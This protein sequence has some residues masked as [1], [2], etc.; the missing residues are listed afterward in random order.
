M[1]ILVTGGAGFI[2]S[3]L[4]ERLLSSGHD[5]VVI[6]NFNNFYDPSQKRRNIEQVA[7]AACTSGRD[8]ILCDGDIRDD[9]FIA[10]VFAQEKPDLVIH[11]AAAAGVR[12]SIENPFLY[13]A[14]NVR[15]T[16]N[17]LE[18]ARN[19][20]VRPFIFASSSS[21]YG[22][23]PKVPFAESD[24]V[25]NPISP[26]AA[27][28]KAGEL[29]CHTYHHLHRMNIACLRFFT[30]YGPRQR[31]DL[32]I[33]KFT[34][35]TE[36]GAPI[37]FYGD[38]TTSRDYTY[39]GDIIDGVE[40]AVA[41]VCAD[42]WRYD[43][44]NLGESRPVELGR[45]VAVIEEALG[46]KAAIER[47]PMQPGDVARTYADLTKSTAILGYRPKTGIEEGIRAFVSWYRDE[48]SR[49]T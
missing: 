26:Y 11:L 12:P 34:R 47:L 16:M 48:K 43:I 4:C 7:L 18:A 22:D 28:K 14:V 29:I 5:L 27:T 40:K 39:V 1:R 31:P 17:L 33:N 41:W 19:N 15:G 36:S 13:E 10:A 20:G 38:G 45:L 21:V 3:H 37:P 42:E 25:D 49:T 8:F 32:A 24:P 30:V 46:K 44:F 6:D 2:G 35:L 23:N 9:E